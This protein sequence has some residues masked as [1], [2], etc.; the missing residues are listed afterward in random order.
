MA[1]LERTDEGAVRTLTLNRPDKRNALN[2]AL[3]QSLRGELAAAREDSRV[4]CL[5]LAAAGKGFCAGADVFEWAEMAEKG[6]PE[7]YDWVGEAHG[8]VQ[9]LAEFPRPTIA[10]VQGAAAGAGVDLALACDFRFAAD[11]AR[12]ICAYMRMAFPPDVGG[13]WLLPR[14]IGPEAAKRFVF[15]GAPW[16]AARALAAGMVSEVHPPGAVMGAARELAAEL[17]AGPTVAQMH[18]KRLID[19]A[20]TRSFAGQLAEE[21]KAGKACAGTEDAREALRAASERRA[22]SF[23][24]R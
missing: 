14:L 17:V 9:E 2:Y 24:G 18:A 5:I 8:L 22:P 19:T 6:R 12:F 3:L 15:T 7:G 21:K 13:T 4:R 10:V 23:V 20:H 1:E 16:D 11:D